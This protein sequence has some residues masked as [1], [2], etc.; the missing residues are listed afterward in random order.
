MTQKNVLEIQVL[1]KL[2]SLPQNTANGLSEILLKE[3]R[4]FHIFFIEFYGKN[5]YLVDDLFDFREYKISKNNITL[6]DFLFKCYAYGWRETF[7]ET[8]I[9]K[10]SDEDIQFIVT[11]IHEGKTT[12]EKIF[13]GFQSNINLN[14]MRYVL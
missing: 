7:V 4:D 6:K 1:T 12:L 11:S 8:F 2:L 13:F 9:Q 5:K 14:I 10:F 3:Q